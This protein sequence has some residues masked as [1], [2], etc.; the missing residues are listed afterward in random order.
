MRSF[1]LLLLLFLL[2][3]LAL[4]QKDVMDSAAFFTDERV[5]EVNLST[6]LKKL[7]TSKKDND[8]QPATVTF[9]CPDSFSV[10]EE[11]RVCARGQFRRK[12]CYMPSTTFDFK[13]PQSPKLSC[14]GKL[15]MVSGCATSASDEQLLLKEYI[16]YKMYN[17]LTEKSFRVRLLRIKYDDTKDKV[18]LYNQYA[19][20]IED[21]KDL[22]KR[23][24]SKEYKNKINT[25]ATDRNYMTLVALFQY[26]IGNTDW[27]VPVAHNIKLILPKKDSTARP[28]VVPYDFDF[29]GL[30]DAPYAIPAPELGT[31]S[32]RERV[33]RGFARNMAEL[34]AVI[35]I[36]KEKKDSIYSLINNFALIKSSEREIMIKYLE[37]FYRIID[38]KNLINDYFIV[39]ARKQ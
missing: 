4:S 20:V 5:I 12:N 28:V 24:K 10:T 14:L 16:I 18:K 39:N 37:E 21:V 17:I 8:F 33:Y 23:N 22:A 35:A 7:M 31:E 15:K 26:M 25:E 2:P 29:A 30:V 1:P 9:I 34:Q 27:A 3:I 6:D 38:S 11:I 13:N 19:F 32:V 36:F